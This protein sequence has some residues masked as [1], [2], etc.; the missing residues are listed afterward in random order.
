MDKQACLTSYEGI[1]LYST[2]RD[3]LKPRTVGGNHNRV[4][5]GKKFA[6]KF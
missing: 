3:V 2:P 6:L 5:T 1:Q 4:F